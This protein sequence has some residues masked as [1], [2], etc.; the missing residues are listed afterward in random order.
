MFW[1]DAPDKRM[2]P[3]ALVRLITFEGQQADFAPCRMLAT[4]AGVRAPRGRAVLKLIGK[5]FFYVLGP[6]RGQVWRASDQTLDWSCVNLAWVTE[7]LA[8]S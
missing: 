8:A 7:L 5:T 1:F 3:E 6:K 4:A 2:Q